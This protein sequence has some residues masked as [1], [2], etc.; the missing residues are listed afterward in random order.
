VCSWFWAGIPHGPVPAAVLGDHYRQF[1]PSFCEKAETSGD[2]SFVSTNDWLT[3]TDILPQ[4]GP[5]PADLPQLKTRISKQPTGI[6]NKL[7]FPS[8][9]DQLNSIRVDRLADVNGK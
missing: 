6:S 9:P 1:W 8:S 5:P 7:A 4:I 2:V 3:N